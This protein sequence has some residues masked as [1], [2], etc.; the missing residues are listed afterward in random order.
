MKLG[1]VAAEMRV[2]MKRIGFADV[3]LPHGLW[4]RLLRLGGPAKRT[5]TRRLRLTLRRQG[6]APSAQ[7]CRVC[8][9]A[10]GVA[11]GTEPTFRKAFVP[12]GGMWDEA[13][14]EWMEVDEVGQGVDA[15]DSIGRGGPVGRVETG[16]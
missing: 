3:H 13:G 14:F 15:V 6:A 9:Q 2:R 8:A 10:F 11:V 1:E 12:N 16:L 7:E 4:L 5:G